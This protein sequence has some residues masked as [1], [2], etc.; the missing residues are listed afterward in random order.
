MKG[1]HLEYLYNLRDGKIKQGLGIGI[2]LDKNLKWKRGQFNVLLGND[3][4]G[5]TMWFNWY[6]LCLSMHHNI[7]WCIYSGENNTAHILR[8]MIVMLSGCDMNEL[9]Y[10]QIM[11]YNNRIEQYFTFID[12]TKMYK[13]E[14]LLKL[15]ANHD[16]DSFLIDPV[17][18]LDRKFQYS[19][20]YEFLNEARNFCNVTN[21]TLYL[22]THPVTEAGRTGNLY[23]KDHM[24][25]NHI[26][27]PLKSHCEGGK[28]YAN[29]CDDMIICHRLTSH[30]EMR[31]YTMI[32]VAKVRDTSTGGATTNMDSPL[33][34]EYNYGKG[35][36]MNHKDSLKDY[37]NVKT[38]TLWN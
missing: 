17:T 36:L 29:R 35:F 25:A 19:D 7:S 18:A 24:W 13:P 32:D 34:F 30:P 23:P 20:T 4:V 11:H 37:R 27:F 10:D 3:N 6:A 1:S 5:K 2:D 12:N 9:S 22:T 14:D 31:Y 28:A 8:D 33:L 26:K 38:N 16:A 21:K 15:F